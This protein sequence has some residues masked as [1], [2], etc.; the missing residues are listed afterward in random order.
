[1][2]DLIL[3][4]GSVIDG[5]GRDAFSADIGIKG[6]RIA[7]IGNLDSAE[8]EQ[9]INISGKVVSPGFIDMHSHAD[10]TILAYPTMDSMLHQGITTF[11]GCMCGHSAA[12]IPRVSRRQ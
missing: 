3:K 10:A 9:V 4:N 2:Y 8:A 5:T 11:V 6:D 1:M 7:R 12:P